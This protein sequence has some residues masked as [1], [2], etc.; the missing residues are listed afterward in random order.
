MLLAEE[1]LLLLIEDST[2]RL[3]V[4]GA[5]TDIALARA[6]LVDCGAGSSTPGPRRSARAAGGSDAVR[7]AVDAMMAAEIRAASLGAVAAASG[8]S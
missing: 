6:Q 7:E 2:G 8:G 5:E 3:L 4:S 1:L